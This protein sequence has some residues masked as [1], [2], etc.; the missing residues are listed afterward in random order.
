MNTHARR[1][2][3]YV[4][5]THKAYLIS[6]LQLC[7]SILHPYVHFFTICL[8][9][10]VSLTGVTFSVG[11]SITRKRKKKR[12]EKTYPLLHIVR[13][14]L[15]LNHIFCINICRTSV[16]PNIGSHIGNGYKNK[17]RKQY[18]LSTQMCSSGGVRERDRQTGRQTD[19]QTDF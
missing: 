11:G 10:C 14:I 9:A 16:V 13:T 15:V 6:S 4:S 8:T 18:G 17:Y 7:V 19:R 2:F 5:M 3:L 1:H 12:K